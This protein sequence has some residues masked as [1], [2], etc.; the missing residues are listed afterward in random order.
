[1][2]SMQAGINVT[3]NTFFVYVMGAAA[4]TINWVCTIRYQSVSGNA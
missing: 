1:M 4:T 2:S 3:G